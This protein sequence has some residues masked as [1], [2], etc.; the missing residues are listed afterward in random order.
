M[1]RAKLIYKDTSQLKEIGLQKESQRI[2]NIILRW[3]HSKGYACYFLVS[4]KKET[5]TIK[6]Q[7]THIL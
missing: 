6:L 3:R 2:E 4:N 5:L 1:P 7:H